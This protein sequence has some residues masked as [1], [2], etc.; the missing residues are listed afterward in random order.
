MHRLDSDQFGRIPLFAPPRSSSS[1]CRRAHHL[2]RAVV[3]IIFFAPSQL[4]LHIHAIKRSSFLALTCAQASLPHCVLCR[5][6][7]IVNFRTHYI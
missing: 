3:V 6:A 7:F 5:F 2:L 4:H 1:L